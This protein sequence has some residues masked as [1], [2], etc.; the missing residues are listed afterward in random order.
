MTRN[1]LEF[2]EEEKIHPALLEEVRRFRADYPAEHSRF[3][4]RRIVPETFYYGKQVWEQAIAAL[5]AGKN[6]LLSGPKATGKNVL[7]DSLC[8]LFDRPAW[9]V[10]FHIG[11]DA[12]G[13]IGS[14]TYDG[15]K[16]VFRPG[17]VYLTAVEGGF[18]VLDEVN[19]ARNEALA[20]LHSA[21]DHRRVID[22]PGYDRIDVSPAARFIGTMNY[23]Y[24]G[25]RELNEALSSRFV[26]LS[27]PAIGGEDLERLLALRFPQLRERLRGQFVKLFLE[28]NE[29]AKQGE[30]SERALDLRGLL[31]AIALIT[32]GTRAGDALDMCLV[33]KTFD[34]YERS[35]I[36]DVIAARIPADLTAGDL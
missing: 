22:V 8:A 23:G 11:M 9:N 7:A 34:E 27:M 16:V 6:L 2:L 1:I 17:P 26:I 33:N 31:D 4:A 5:L 30:I 15:E 29:K 21:L 10:S 14:D 12:Y 19:M 32:Y 18:A 20:V 24:A 3:A 36:H 28:I 25:T 35:L 13:L